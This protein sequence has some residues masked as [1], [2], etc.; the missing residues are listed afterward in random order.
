MRAI[1]SIWE[2]LLGPR[3]VRTNGTT[4]TYRKSP[5]AVYD[6]V[7]NSE[8]DH[9][10]RVSLLRVSL[11]NY[12]DSTPGLRFGPALIQW[13]NVFIFNKQFIGTTSKQIETTYRFL[14]IVSI[15]AVAQTALVL[16]MNSF[17]AITG[18]VLWRAE[19][20]FTLPQRSFRNLT[21][22]RLHSLILFLVGRALGED[23]VF[24][25]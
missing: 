13:T 4:S 6:W 20:C 24:L 1:S 3:V 5:I 10:V 17:L 2:L 16:K 25:R 21:N 8:I 18:P 19:A 9:F 7:L 23:T 22:V 12:E 15:I 11:A 14:Q